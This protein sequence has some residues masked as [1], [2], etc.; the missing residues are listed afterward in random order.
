M[1]NFVDKFKY[2]SKI[3][4]NKNRLFNGE[5]QLGVSAIFFYFV[6]QSGFGISHVWFLLLNWAH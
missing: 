4:V 3:I 5:Q 1:A 6:G 2:F